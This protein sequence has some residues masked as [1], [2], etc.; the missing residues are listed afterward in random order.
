MKTYHVNATQ[1]TNK[2]QSPSMVYSRSPE[3]EPGRWAMS[4]FMNAHNKD[5]LPP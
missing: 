2:A 4:L 3:A 1:R 5:L